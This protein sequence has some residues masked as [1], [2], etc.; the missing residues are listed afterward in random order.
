MLAFGRAVPGIREGEM[1]GRITVSGL[2]AL[3]MLLT[4]HAAFAQARI[5]VGT[6]N[7]MPGCQGMFNSQTREPVFVD[8]LRLAV[9]DKC[10]PN[11]LRPR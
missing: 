3:V 8:G 1:R 7:S 11:A 9:N 6:S 5:I 10:G 2:A 4:A